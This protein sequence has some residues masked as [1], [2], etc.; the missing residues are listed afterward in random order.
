MAA[1]KNKGII[2]KKIGL[3]KAVIDIFKRPAEWWGVQGAKGKFSEMSN[4]ALLPYVNSVYNQPSKYAHW[5][6]VHLILNYNKYLPDKIAMVQ[7]I[8]RT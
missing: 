4:L 1:G 2:K 6:T 7:T 8:G 3:F 5:T